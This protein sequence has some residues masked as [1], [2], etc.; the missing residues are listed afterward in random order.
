MNSG[1][2]TATTLRIAID[3]AKR[4][5]W[6]R[7]EGEFADVSSSALELGY[8]PVP[9][10]KH[11]PE[12]ALI[13]PRDPSSARRMSMSARYGLGSLPLHTDGAHMAMPP[14]LTILTSDRESGVG[15]YLLYVGTGAMPPDVEEAA[16]HGVFAVRDGAAV[17]SVT[18]RQR[19]G[20]LR[21][22]PV[23][24]APRDDL[25]RAVVRYFE[26]ATY[27]AEVHRWQAREV[28]VIDNTSV[29][30]GREKAENSPDR[31]LRRLM[32]RRAP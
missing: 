1:P 27:A 5:G 24:M 20:A 19:D 16:R 26:Q 14:E 15:T 11:D 4:T 18:A 10:R 32:L 12:V 25:A 9:T 7:Y 17:R 13:Q 2:T 28:L 31:E 29:V 8:V 3:E 30:H 23:A 21:F 6:A 22:D